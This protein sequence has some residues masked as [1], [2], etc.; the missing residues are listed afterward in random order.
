MMKKVLNDY[1]VNRSTMALL[2]VAHID[3]RTIVL[4]ENQQFFVQKTP[5]QLVKAACIEGGATYDG[6]RIA[7]SYRTGTKQKVPIPI[8]PR[9]NIFAFPTHSP[10]AFECSW[11]F[12]HH[13]KSVKKFISPSHNTTQSMILF[14]NSQKI[15]LSESH[16]ILEKQMQRTAICIL[17]F[18]KPPTLT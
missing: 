6:R 17:G 2:S 15:N 9:E 8:N 1:E 11:I 14:N 12:Y 16:Y 3:Y 13:V 7:V 5:T 4:E 18:S 10:K